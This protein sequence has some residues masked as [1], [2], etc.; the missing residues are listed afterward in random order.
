MAKSLS[1]LSSC[2][3]EETFEEYAK[4]NNLFYMRSTITKSQEEENSNLEI[5]DSKEANLEDGISFYIS[6]RSLEQE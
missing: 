5:F 1:F 6:L 3:E 4:I 2:P